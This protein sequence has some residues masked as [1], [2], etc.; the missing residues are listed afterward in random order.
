MATKKALLDG[1]RFHAIKFISNNVVNPYDKDQFERP[2]KLHRRFPQDTPNIPVDA[3]PD[4][5]KE[6][7][8]EAIRKAEKAAEREATQAQIAPTDKA[9]A[10]KKRQPFK[11]KTEDVYYPTD[12]P[13]AQKRARLRYEEGRPWHLRR[14]SV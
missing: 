9:A 13:E 4:D 8:K 10:A 1:L 5:D 14:A 3:N 7:E 6:R 12:T 2:V 11:K